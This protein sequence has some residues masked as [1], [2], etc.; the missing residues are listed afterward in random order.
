MGLREHTYT[1]K[2]LHE[3]S[4]SMDSSLSLLIAARDAYVGREIDHVEFAEIAEISVAHLGKIIEACLVAG[5][6]GARNEN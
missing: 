2:A 3:I 4:P 1:T 5:A 6:A